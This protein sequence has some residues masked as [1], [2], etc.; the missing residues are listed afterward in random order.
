MKCPHCQKRMTM[1]SQYRVKG[2]RYGSVPGLKRVYFCKCCCCEYKTVETLET[3]LTE[4]QEQ[5]EKRRQKWIRETAS[6]KQEIYYL[7]M[8]VNT[9]EGKLKRVRQ[10]LIDLIQQTI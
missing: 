3:Y 8:P 10:G 7:T 6:L 1:K 2:L 5:F 4:Q 9:G